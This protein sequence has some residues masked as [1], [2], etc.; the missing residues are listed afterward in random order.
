MEQKRFPAWQGATQAL[1]AA[2]LFGLSAPLIKLAGAGAGAWTT[3]ALLYT[4]AAFAGVLSRSPAGRDA[5]VRRADLPRIALMALCGA[6]F[7]PF[8]LAWGL[9]HTGALSASLAL[10]LE[11]V[12]SVLLAVLCFREHLGR[13]VA[14]ALA[15]MTAGA[16]LLVFDRAQAGATGLLGLVAVIGATLAWA[17]DNTLSRPLAERDPG[18]VV[19]R[20]AAIGVLCSAAFAWA[21]GETPPPAPNA[22]A[23]F[24]TGALG[25]GFSLRLYLLAQRSFGAARTASVFAAA[26]FFGALAALALGDHGLTGPLMAA[27]LLMAAGVI[28]HLTESHHHIHTHETLEHEHAHTHDDAHHNHVH[29]IAPHRP[30]S[31]WH[32]HETRTHAH[33]H[34]PDAHHLHQH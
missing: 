4:G 31:H 14:A 16:A 17:V 6:A 19:W 33:A 27:A 30:H 7:A 1:A 22:L 32:R 26:P 2:L 28:V 21:T 25:Y 5:A 34:A 8:A 13:R 29:G 15:L 3:A 9:Q 20:K 18:A 24:A 12:F 11:A 10:T 23:L